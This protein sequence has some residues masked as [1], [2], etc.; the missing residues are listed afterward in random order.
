MQVLSCPAQAQL[1]AP[2]DAVPL[3][4]EVNDQLAAAASRHPTRFSAFASLPWSD[5]AAAVE[6]LKRAVTDLGLKGV[7]LPGRPSFG[8]VLLDNEA[9]EPILA[10]AASLGVPLYIHP[11]YP[12]PDVQKVYYSGL[13]DELS[14]RLSIF[15]WGW[16]NEAGIQ[17]VRLILSGA[18]ERH[19]GLQVISGHWGE[20]VPFYLARLDQALPPKA[21]GFKRTVTEIYADHVHVTPS[22][23]FEYPH[24]LF[25]MQVLGAERII[26]SVDFP[27]IGN[28]GGRTFIE[29]APISASDKQK[30]SH[31]NV[32]ALLG[33]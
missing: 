25:C 21:T 28:E 14:A 18:F 12:H 3:V 1:L 9:F 16:H 31:G 6:E 4:R 33:L 22:G 17:V 26:H 5:P 7:L 23:I 29:D 10:T 15:G 24:L 8:P 13:G 32:E 30:I 20:L 2:G 27:L 11:G 19:P